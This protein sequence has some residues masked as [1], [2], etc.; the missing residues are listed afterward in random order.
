[1]YAQ[2]PL[3]RLCCGQLTV[4]CTH[5]LWLVRQD[6]IA[7]CICSTRGVWVVSSVTYRDVAVIRRHT[8]MTGS[9]MTL[10]DRYFSSS[11]EELQ[12]QLA[13]CRQSAQSLL[14]YWLI[15]WLSWSTQNG[16]DWTSETLYPASLLSSTDKPSLL[17]AVSNA[18]GLKGLKQRRVDAKR[19]DGQQVDGVDVVVG[20][21]TRTRAIIELRLASRHVSIGFS[22]CCGSPRV[23]YALSATDSPLV[24]DSTPSRLTWVNSKQSS[25]FSANHLSAVYRVKTT[26]LAATHPSTDWAQRRVASFMQQIWRDATTA[27]SRHAYETDCSILARKWS[28]MMMTM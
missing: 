28:I 26:I 15:D 21:N 25:F 19:Q 11:I 14:R 2:I 18:T 4:Q 5:V 22:S 8:T 9:S 27:P 12:C 7:T 13:A 17:L 3:V 23:I 6:W 20:W 24:T 1:M 10:D 16:P